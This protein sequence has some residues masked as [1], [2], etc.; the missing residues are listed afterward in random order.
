MAGYKL[1]GSEEGK[2]AAIRLLNELN[3]SRFHP[4]ENLFRRGGGGAMDSPENYP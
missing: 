3:I 1:I 2:E 4:V